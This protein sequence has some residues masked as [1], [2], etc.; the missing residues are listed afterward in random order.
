MVTVGIDLVLLLFRVWDILAVSL[1]KAVCL[2]GLS[3]LPVSL[4]VLVTRGVVVSR[5]RRCRQT[6]VS[7]NKEAIR[8]CRVVK[9]LLGFRD[10]K[11]LNFACCKVKARRKKALVRV[12]LFCCLV[13]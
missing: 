7:R 10:I 12:K 11:P 1:N 5:C 3:R 13:S 4:T 9:I 6:L 2:N 8:P